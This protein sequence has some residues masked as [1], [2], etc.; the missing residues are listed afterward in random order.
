MDDHISQQASFLFDICKL[1]IAI[2][3][4][5]KDSEFIVVYF[6]DWLQTKARQPNLLF[7]LPIVKVGSGFLKDINVKWK[8]NAVSART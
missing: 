3:A 1:C 6:L 8:K 7:Y 2:P 5:K 4:F